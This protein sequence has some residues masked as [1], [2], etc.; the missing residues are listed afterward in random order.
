MF[1]DWHW[2][3]RERLGYRNDPDSYMQLLIST[4][5][6]IDVSRF[7]ADLV[8]GGVFAIVAVLSVAL[9][10]RDWRKKFAISRRF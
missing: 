7:W 4:V 6:G 9:N 10:A 2:S 3:V 5:L 1:T 8:T